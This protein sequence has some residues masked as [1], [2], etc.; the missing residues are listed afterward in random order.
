M[1]TPMFRRPNQQSRIR[2]EIGQIRIWLLCTKLRLAVAGNEDYSLLPLLFYSH[3]LE[4]QLSK[5][6]GG[7][8]AY[9]S[10]GRV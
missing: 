8:V 7:K 3:R 2:I 10:V 4:I 5:R 1:A 6:L 9:I